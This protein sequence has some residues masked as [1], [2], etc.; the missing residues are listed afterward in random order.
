MGTPSSPAYN[1]LIPL[2]VHALSQVTGGKRN[3]LNAAIRLRN[4]CAI[5]VCEKSHAPPSP[6]ALVAAPEGQCFETDGT[7]S[8]PRRVRLACDG[9]VARGSTRRRRTTGRFE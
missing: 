8:L 5:A 3:N 2:C 9:C 1:E 7:A 6:G 4:R